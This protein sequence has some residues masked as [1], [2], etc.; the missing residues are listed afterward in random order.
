MHRLLVLLINLN[1]LPFDFNLLIYFV[2]YFILKSKWESLKNKRLLVRKQRSQT[3]FLFR[4]QLILTNWIRNESIKRI[5]SFCLMIFP[6]HNFRPLI[7]WRKKRS[8]RWSKI[9][10]FKIILS[11]MPLWTKLKIKLTKIESKSWEL[12]MARSSQSLWS[13]RVASRLFWKPLRK[14]L[15]KMTSNK[16]FTQMRGLIL[17]QF[18][19]KL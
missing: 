14:T 11:S 13:P 3:Q 17:T 10:N 5:M 8:H 1:Y 19:I 6:F 16:A 15:K 18:Q 9:P 2:K 7:L 4:I 12:K